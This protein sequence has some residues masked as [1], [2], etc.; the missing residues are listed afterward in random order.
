M[1]FKYKIS[2]TPHQIVTEYYKNKGEDISDKEI[3]KLEKHYRQHEPEQFLAMYDAI[4]DN[5][6]NTTKG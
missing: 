6:K 3:Q 4:R 5:S 2:K 1:L